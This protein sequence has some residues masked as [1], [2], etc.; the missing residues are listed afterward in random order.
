[1]TVNEDFVCSVDV[2]FGPPI[3]SS[4]DANNDVFK[5]AN[6][7]P[8]PLPGDILPR[9]LTEEEVHRVDILSRLQFFL[10]TAPTQISQV[11][12]TVPSRW[13]FATTVNAQSSV[14]IN[15]FWLPNGEC[16]SCVLWNGLYHITGTDVVRAL[17]FRFEAFGR[18]V[19]LAKKWE[20]GVFSDLRNLKPGVDASLEEAKSPLLD[21]L[22]R[23]GCIRTQKKVR[24]HDRF[25]VPHDRLFLDA[26][27]RDLKREKSG[28]QSTTVV[29]GEPARSFTYDP[30]HSLYEQFSRQNPGIESHSSLSSL[31]YPVT[32][33]TAHLNEPFANVMPIDT[34]NAPYGCQS[35]IESPI[36]PTRPLD[37][38]C[39]VL[40]A[41]SF[42]IFTGSPAYKRRKTVTRSPSFSTI[43]DSRAGS[44]P[45]YDLMNSLPGG[46]SIRSNSPRYQTETKAHPLSAANRPPLF[47]H[48]SFNIGGAGDHRNTQRYQCPIDFCA[49]PFKRLE[50]LKR[51]I[52][53]HTLEKPF[54]CL[55][56]SRS[57]SRQDNLL[58]HH[59][60][61]IKLDDVSVDMSNN[62]RSGTGTPSNEAGL[63]ERY[64]TA[65]PVVMSW[66]PN[67]LDP[68]ILG[69]ADLLSA[70]LPID[71]A[72]IPAFFSATFRASSAPCLAE[73]QAND[74]TAFAVNASD[75]RTGDQ[76]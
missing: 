54:K 58:Q 37:S 51:H 43:Y 64:A 2:P 9:P 27:E 18:P 67:A 73:Q 1:M 47:T 52:R 34:P 6:L 44:S 13:Q 14:G 19:H 31:T 63:R 7:Y 55:Q 57:F 22:F 36:L 65:S 72:G 41:P 59:R 17:A 23:N 62:V 48:S 16:V 21:L 75:A 74:A 76:S 56:C 8:L 25:S 5:V 11:S 24:D 28:H 35:P 30:R 29:V 45:P 20:E 4:S 49:R 69:T 46:P 42:P 61:H 10:A 32:A 70:F 66:E 60:I 40:P 38:A 33:A 3:P 39:P 68:A 15:K 12:S 50:H 26:L 53:T 71:S